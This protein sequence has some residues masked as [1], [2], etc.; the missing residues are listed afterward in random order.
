MPVGPPF[1]QK[2]VGALLVAAPSL[3]D[4]N[5]V[6]TVILV[7]DHGD[8]GAL[9]LVLNRPTGVGVDEILGPWQPQATLAPPAVIF[10]GG[11]VEPNAVIG[12]ARSV[13]ADDGDD[14]S[15]GHGAF[16]SI[17]GPV[18]TIDLSVPPDEQPLSLAGVRLFSG[19]A[20]WSP[21]QLESELEDNAWFVVA[22]DAADALRDEPEGLWHDVLRRQRGELAMLASYPVHPSMN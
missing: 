20:G 21:G 2:L 11:P 16:R 6:R 4:E 17:L 12:L 8:E 5:F 13:G 14:R 15:G 19:Y 22:A 10:R 3:L 7:L 1:G 18:G 9:G